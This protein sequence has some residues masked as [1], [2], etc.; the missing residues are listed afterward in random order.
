MTPAAREHFEVA[1]ELFGRW[2]RERPPL[3]SLGT[4]GVGENPL[5]HR[6]QRL[7]GEVLDVQLQPRPQLLDAAALAGC[8]A[9]RDPTIGT[10]AV[11]ASQVPL[12]PQCEMNRSVAGSNVFCCTH[13]GSARGARAK[14]IQWGN[15]ER[16]YLRGPTGTPRRAHR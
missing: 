5:H 10:P 11:R 2:Q 8:S 12:K 15:G 16:A 9:N 4:R 3:D 6:S 14:P 7:R 13:G 1:D